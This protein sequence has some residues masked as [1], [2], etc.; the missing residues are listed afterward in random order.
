MMLI[1]WMMKRECLPFESCMAQRK[2]SFGC[3][4]GTGASSSGARPP[5]TLMEK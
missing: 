2:F 5:P 3:G 4:P 1:G